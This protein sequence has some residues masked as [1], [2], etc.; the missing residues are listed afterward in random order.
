MKKIFYILFILGC[1]SNL[2]GQKKATVK[3]ANKLFERKAYVKAAEMY[4]QLGTT[5]EVLQNLG[6]SYFYNFYEE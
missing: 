3:Q 6:D 5:K 2:F 1:F 4:E